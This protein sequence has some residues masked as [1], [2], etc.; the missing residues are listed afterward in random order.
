VAEAAAVLEDLEGAVSA[1][2]DRVG[3][4][5]LKMWKFEDLEMWRFGNLKMR[6]CFVRQ[7]GIFKSPN[8]HIIKLI[9]MGLL[10]FSALESCSVFKKDCGCPSA[11][12]GKQRR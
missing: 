7:Q 2:A 4:G 11:Y 6:G 8:L 12:G 10:A 1:A 3:D 9:L 5:D